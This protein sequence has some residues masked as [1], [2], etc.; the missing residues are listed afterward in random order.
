VIDLTEMATAKANGE[1]E[2]NETY[3]FRNSVMEALECLDELI[4]VNWAKVR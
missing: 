1:K 4:K 2:N 3:V